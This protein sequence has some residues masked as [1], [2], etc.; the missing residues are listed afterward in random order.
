MEALI[1]QYGRP[2]L[3]IAIFLTLAVVVAVVILLIAWVREPQGPISPAE[4]LANG[5]HVVE[6]EVYCQSTDLPVREGSYEV[7][8]YS[9]RPPAQDTNVL[10]GH[11]AQ[12][13]LA[14]DW[15]GQIRVTYGYFPFYTETT[16]MIGGEF[17][18]E[19]QRIDLNC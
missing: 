1:A 16:L 15:I 2:R 8:T 17:G 18:W 9:G 19:P 10:S 14:R 12:I 13:V 5:G 7:L 4:A 6:L 3:W 11:R